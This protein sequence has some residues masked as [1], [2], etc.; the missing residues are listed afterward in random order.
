VDKLHTNADTDARKE[1]IHHQ[2]GTGDTQAA[3]GNHT[4]ATPTLDHGANLVGL[5][6]DDHI[7]YGIIVVS[8]TEPATPR[9]GTIWVPSG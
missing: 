3:A 5:A 1:S 8:A 6:D 7:Q 2:I 4:H 9:V